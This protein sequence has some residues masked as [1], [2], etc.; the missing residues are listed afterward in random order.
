MGEANGVRE[1][2]METGKR[3]MESGE[4]LMESGRG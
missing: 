3:L 2:L 4:R 1:R